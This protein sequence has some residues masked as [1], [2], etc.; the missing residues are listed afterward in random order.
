MDFAGGAACGAGLQQRRGDPVII[1]GRLDRIDSRAVLPDLTPDEAERLTA[2][3]ND[4]KGAAQPEADNVKEQWIGARVA[5]IVTAEDQ[6]DPEKVQEAEGI[7][8]RAL[9]T[10]VLAGDFMVPVEVS[11]KVEMLPVGALLDNRDRYH[12]CMTRDPLETG[13]DGGRFV[14]R[15]FLLQARPVLHSFAHGGK[16]YR[17]H[18]APARVELVKGHTAEAATAS[19]ELLRRDPVTFDFGGQLAGLAPVSPDTQ[20]VAQSLQ[21]LVQA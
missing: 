17:L 7:A 2:I 4:A 12:N 18:R 3:N 15:L 8:R 6:G 14:G 13:Y 10:G 11:G 9:E 5:E 19:I 20:T 21:K 16:A 1:N